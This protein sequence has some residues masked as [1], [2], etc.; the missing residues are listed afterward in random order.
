MKK[1]VKSALCH[2]LEKCLNSADMV[3]PSGWKISRTAYLVDIMA[4][5]R[6]TSTKG[7]LHLPIFVQLS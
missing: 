5:V 2:E 3:P 1:P 6:K 4:N 7:L